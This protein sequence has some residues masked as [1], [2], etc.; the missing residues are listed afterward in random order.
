MSA[1][2][3][4]KLGISH[5]AVN[6]ASDAAAEGGPLSSLAWVFERERAAVAG[7]EHD[8]FSAAWKS[9]ERDAWLALPCVLLPFV[10]LHLISPSPHPTYSPSPQPLTRT[11]WHIWGRCRVPEY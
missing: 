8:T 7:E 1:S 9:G 2:K 11:R 6:A 5:V 3:H 4:L 10:A